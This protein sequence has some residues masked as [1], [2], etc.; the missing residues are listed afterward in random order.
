MYKTSLQLLLFASIILA[1]GQLPLGNRGTI[2]EN[3][4]WGLRRVGNWSVDKVK[5]TAK[6][7]KWLA[8]FEF[9]KTV[10]SWL[11]LKKPENLPK[12]APPERV[13]PDPAIESEE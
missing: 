11:K 9:S 10:D 2:G 7:S 5:E 13:E 3:Y 6:N 4:I 8:G 12:I 1:I